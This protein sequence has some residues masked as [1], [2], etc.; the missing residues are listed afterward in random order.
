MRL[1]W[2]GTST[3]TTAETCRY[4]GIIDAPLLSPGVGPHACQVSCQ[5]CGRH[6]RW[7]SLHAPAERQARRTKARW[8]AMQQLPP[9]TAQL[10]FLQALG[11]Q[12]ATPATMADASERIEALKR[13]RGH[14]P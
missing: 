11:D 2:L 3:A 4:C 12:A 8:Q 7:V 14:R 1:P 13:K 9:S 10:S 5:H 6:W